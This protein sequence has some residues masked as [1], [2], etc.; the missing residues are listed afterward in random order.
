M[1]ADLMHLSPLDGRYAHQLGA[2]REHFSEYALIRARVDIEIR[3]LIALVP[4]VPTLHALSDQHT[5]ALQAL[6]DHFTPKD[7]HA[8]KDIEKVIHHDVK[9]VEYWLCQQL[10]T[11]S[12]GPYTPFIHFGCTSDDINNLAYARLIKRTRVQLVENLHTVG[13]ILQSLAHRYAHLPM[14][15]RTHG[16]SATPTTLGKEF[17]TFAYRLYQAQRIITDIP[18]LGKCNSTVGNLN[19]LSVAYPQEDWFTHTRL[20]VEQLDLVFNPYTTQIENHDGLAQLF[21]ALL[22]TNVI[23]IDCTRDMWGYLSLGYLTQTIRA[24]DVGSSTMP[25]KVNPIDF[26]NA[27]GNLGLANALFNHFVEKLPISRWQR[28]LSDSTVLRNIGVSFGHC[29][30]AYQALQNGLH[31]L[32]ADEKVITH[33]LNQH[34]EVLS[35]AI[36]TI[37]RAQGITQ[38]YDI[39]KQKTRHHS[40]M[41]Q[42]S[43]QALVRSLPLSPANKRRLLAL[44]PEKYTGIAGG[45][46][47]QV[48]CFGHRTP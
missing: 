27:E 44:T 8:I 14:L 1:F 3:W 35:E 41:N 31:T 7:A 47:E 29:L 25:H 39:V 18:I 21:G 28:D 23:L 32:V 33:D 22:H 2:L 15:S 4:K 13:E 19:T 24:T 43:Y 5:A 38:A 34:W 11:L 20:F 17:A 10:H 30:L 46:A 37:M 26:E 40:T 12:L 6:V 42:K 9:A 48:D 36:Q 45:L 16:Q